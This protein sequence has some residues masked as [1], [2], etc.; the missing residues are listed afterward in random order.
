MSMPNPREVF[1]E[2]AIS[3][4]TGSFNT[5]E[6]TVYFAA[7]LDLRR[8]VSG[9]LAARDALI[10]NEGIAYFRPW[11]DLAAPDA[12]EVEF[13]PFSH[14]VW[15][16]LHR[17]SDAAHNKITDL[18]IPSIVRIVTNHKY[19]APPD[20]K[21]KPTMNVFAEDII[22]DGHSYASL[23]FGIANINTESGE[24]IDSDGGAAVISPRPNEEIAVLDF[25]AHGRWESLNP[26][27]DVVER[28]QVKIH[29]RS[30]R[31]MHYVLA[32]ARQVMQAVSDVEPSYI[33]VPETS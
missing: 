28:Q 33:S 7:A 9:F 26:P 31:D 18:R 29:S 19:T 13:A 2:S 8:E 22:L 6:L 23:F 17:P 32:R 3:E 5:Q 14:D 20:D 24:V 27:E 12:E 10:G 16:Q 1:S 21:G 4:F 30:P 15:V 11:L 25:A